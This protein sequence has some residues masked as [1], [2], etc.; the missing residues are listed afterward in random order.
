[1]AIELTTATTNTLSEIRDALFVPSKDALDQ[2][3]GLP[4]PNISL[5]G[6]SILD[7]LNSADGEVLDVANSPK[8]LV[9]DFSQEF[10]NDNQIFI[11]MMIYK[12]RNISNK[13]GF[14]VPIGSEIKPWGSNF[15]NRSGRD[16]RFH[17][18]EVTE[19]TVLPVRY[20]HLPVSNLNQT[21][22]LGICLNNHF[23]EDTVTFRNSS[24]VEQNIQLIVPSKRLSNHIGSK[25]S[26]SRT[27]RPLYI[28]FRYI[29]WIPNLNNGRGQIISGPLSKTIQIR[30]KNFP[31]HI[32]N[33]QSTHHGKPVCDLNPTFGKLNFVCSFL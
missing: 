24:N 27:Y 16:L 28:A 3:N 31:F 5:G 18:G 2:K 33:E 21:I 22:N 25:Y 11:E 29:Q 23:H 19:S 9:S 6:R 30:N 7:I 4:A 20:N 8:L 13:R 14:L 26:Y 1:M 10:L 17:V 12:R 15:Y 32:N